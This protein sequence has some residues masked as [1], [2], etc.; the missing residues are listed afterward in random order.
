M[1]MKKYLQYVGPVLVIG[2]F[3][4]AGALLH[5]EL[6]QYHMHDIKTAIEEIPAWRI[7]VALGLTVLNYLVLIG[8]DYLAVRAIRHPLPLGKIAL[9]SFTGFTTS[10]NF[11]AILGGTSVRY[12]LYSAWGMSAGEILQLVVMMGVTFWVGAFALAGVVFVVQPIQMPEKLDLPFNSVHPLGY[13]LL[14]VT[15]VYVLLTATPWRSLRVGEVRIQVPSTGMTI[16]QLFVAAAD[17]I[18]AAGCLY[19]LISHDLTVGYWQ[20]LGVYL[21]A[22]VAVIITH[23]PGG[24]GVFELVILTVSAPQAL[25]SMVAALLLFRIIYYLLPL[26]VALL[27]LAGNEIALQRAAAARMWKAFGRLSGNLVAG[28]LAWSTL[29]AGAVLLVSGA[30][31]A[32]QRRQPLLEGSIPLSLIEVSHFT[33]SIVGALL[34]LLALGLHRRLDTAWWLA[35]GLLIVGVV[36]SVLKGMHFEIA[37]ILLIITVSLIV[38]RRR[39]YRHGA[40]LHERLTT[41]WIAAVSLAVVTSLYLGLFA[42]KHVDYANSL[43]WQ[44]TL[45]G[46]ASRFLRSS[47]GAVLVLLFFTVWKMRSPLRSLPAPQSAAQREQAATIASHS[48]KALSQLALLGDKQFQFN[49]AGSGFIMYARH[50]RSWIAMG[51]PVAQKHEQP[52]LVWDFRELVDQYDGWPVFYQV[53]EECLPMYLDQGLAILKLGEEARVRLES[54]SLD[55]EDRQELRETYQR[56]QRAGVEFAVLKPDEVPAILPELKAVSDAWLVQQATAEKGF[57]FGYFDEDYLKRFPCA[58]VRDAGRIV[59]FSNLWC[60][61]ENQELSADLMRFLPNLPNDGVEFLLIEVMLWGQQAG[62]QWFNLGMAPLSDFDDRP[63]SRLWSRAMHLAYRHG[64]RFYSAEGLRAY[65]DKFRPVWRPRYLASPGGIT[66][67]RILADLT[68]LIAKDHHAAKSLVTEPTQ[69]ADPTPRQEQASQSAASA[70]ACPSKSSPD[71]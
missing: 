53:S 26:F 58:V 32:L 50:A 12:R 31:P 55:G 38:F 57:A 25:P 47:A 20:F 46:D 23:V 39:F 40:L 51:D 14:A 67:P 10:T 61:A 70:D 54:F 63:L 52:E 45:D 34:L 8:Y 66:L 15:V 1:F 60:G 64:D 7:G 71:E 28:L 37:A 6:R 30:L 21:L 5:R 42:H 49:Q 44:F 4:V 13:I 29:I 41:G 35:V 59:A 69:T 3:L 2:V 36:S 16:M 19:M 24:L 22:V 43:W 27:L 33:G 62:Y 17:L 18:V 56:C 68:A 9:A 48:D 11:G 65:K